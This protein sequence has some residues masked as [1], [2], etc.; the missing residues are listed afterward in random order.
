MVTLEERVAF[1]EG[2]V[3][4]HSH[5]VN[6]I[7]EALVHFEQRVD[8]RFE[9]VDKRF[10]SLE[11]RMARGFEALDSKMDR[12]FEALDTKMAR[13]FTWLVGITVT[14]VGATL[15]AVLMR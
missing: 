11:T 13:Q 4:E 1:L 15:T 8:R 5:M 12:G 10:E 14:L 9:A 7:R 3:L 2:Q 6:G